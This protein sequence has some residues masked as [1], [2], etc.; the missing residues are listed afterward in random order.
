MLQHADDCTNFIDD[1]YSY[2]ELLK[3]FISFGK[4]SGSKI[5]PDKTEIVLL[6]DWRGNAIVFLSL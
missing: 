6:G 5:N 4:V 2:D 1:K 3:E